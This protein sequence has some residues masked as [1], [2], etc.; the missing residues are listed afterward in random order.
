MWFFAVLVIFVCFLGW[1]DGGFMVDEIDGLMVGLLN[2]AFF[3]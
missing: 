2:A 1:M 3:G